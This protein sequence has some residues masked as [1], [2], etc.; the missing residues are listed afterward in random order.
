MDN[1]KPQ[2]VTVVDVDIALGSMVYL[3]F[4]FVIAVIPA[5]VL[6][7]A[8]VMAVIIIG[9]GLFTAMCARF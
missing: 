2:R 6:I 5:L 3:I 9:G 7:A 1:E 4:K 8:C